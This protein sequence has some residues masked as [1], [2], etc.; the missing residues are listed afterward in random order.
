MKVVDAPLGG[1]NL[2]LADLRQIVLVIKA[3]PKDVA[4]VSQ[5]PLQCVGCSLLLCLL[6]CR[7]FALAILYLPIPDILYC[8]NRLSTNAVASYLMICPIPQGYSACDR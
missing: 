5:R 3:I 1:C 4:E 7:R 2:D 6:E 8:I